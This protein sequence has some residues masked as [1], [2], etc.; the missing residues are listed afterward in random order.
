VTIEAPVT[1]RPLP[2]EASTP[3]EAQWFALLRRADAAKDRKWAE[4][5]YAGYEVFQLTGCC[6]KCSG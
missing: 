2:R 5:I 3:M 1:A 4:A 6:W